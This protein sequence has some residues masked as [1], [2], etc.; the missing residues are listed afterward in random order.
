MSTCGRMQLVMDDKL[1]AP[2][3]SNVTPDVSIVSS[4]LSILLVVSSF[5]VLLAPC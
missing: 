5:G 1:F 2:L 4:L 3:S